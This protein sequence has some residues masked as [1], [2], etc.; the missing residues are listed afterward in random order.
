MKQKTLIYTT[1]KDHWFMSDFVDIAKMQLQSNALTIERYDAETI[2]I[3]DLPIEKG[4]DG[5]VR[6]SWV[7]FKK[8]LTEKAVAQGYN[9]VV[10]HMSKKERARFKISESLG[11]T[12][13]ADKDNVIEF[14]MCAD[15]GAKAKHYKGKSEFWRIFL[16]ESAHGSERFLIGPTSQL[17]HHYDYVLHDIHNI[18]TLFDWSKWTALFDTL[19]GLTGVRDALAAGQLLPAVARKAEALKKACKNKGIEIKITGGFRTC[20]AQNALYAQGRTTGG[21]IVTNARCGESLHNY[22]VAFDICFNTKTPYV[23][24]WVEV[25]KMGEALGLEWGGRWVSFPDRPHFQF[26]AGYTLKEFQTG[27]VDYKKYQ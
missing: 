18:Y 2:K 26:V 7:W 19:E 22:G 27:K 15:K 11:G 1:S 16:H 13:M 23:G 20:E 6:P 4:N 14:W 3:K 21:A 12:Y 9:Q 24:P 17:V 10:F 5:K 8:N 25:A